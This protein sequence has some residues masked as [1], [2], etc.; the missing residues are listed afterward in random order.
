MTKSQ[1]NLKNLFSDSQFK[2]YERYDN[3]GQIMKTE[4]EIVDKE[5]QGVV[6]EVKKID[7]V[8]EQE[9]PNKTPNTK[10]QTRG[11]NSLADDCCNNPCLNN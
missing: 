1:Q 3:T 8:S 11:S 7:N 4:I 5:F 6:V 9:L 2:S 10:T